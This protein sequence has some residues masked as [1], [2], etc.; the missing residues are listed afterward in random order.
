MHIRYFNSTSVLHTNIIFLGLVTSLLNH[1][2]PHKSMRLL[3]RVLMK[4][5]FLVDMYFFTWKQSAIVFLSGIFYY[6]SKLVRPREILHV[7]AHA[8]VTVGHCLKYL[9]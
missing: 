8:L 9:K 6:V 5:C 4:I 2:T 1:G 3:D 7:G